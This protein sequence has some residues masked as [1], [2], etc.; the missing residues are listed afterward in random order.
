MGPG[1][2]AAANPETGVVNADQGETT[3]Q[4]ED[5]DFVG[6]VYDECFCVQTVVSLW[7][8]FRR[9]RMGSYDQYESR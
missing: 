3:E 1:G 8:G 5:G 9:E 6:G 4:E 7:D 2:R